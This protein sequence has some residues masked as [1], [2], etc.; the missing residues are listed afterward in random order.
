MLLRLKFI[1]ENHGGVTDLI[2]LGF[3]PGVKKKM[4]QLPVLQA[5]KALFARLSRQNQ[6][7][8][9]LVSVLENSAT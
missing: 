6:A 4:D 8:V 2:A 5:E 3:N 1:P 9:G 7:P